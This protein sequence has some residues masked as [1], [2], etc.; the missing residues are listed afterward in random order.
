MRHL[1]ILLLTIVISTPVWAGGKDE[2]DVFAR[3]ECQRD[4]VIAGDS[5]VI[6]IVLYSSHPFQK[7]ECTTK[8]IKIKGCTPRLVARRGNRQQQ[9]VRLSQGIYYAIVWDSYVVG[10]AQPTEIKFPE[11]QFDCQVE[12]VESEGYDPFDPFGFFGRPQRKSRE[13]Q[14]KCKAP[15]FV[16]PVIERPK[17]STQEAISSGSRIA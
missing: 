15:A 10:H 13:V 16:L 8:N 2:A 6:N 12:I 3:Y 14:Q 7:A 5:I 4:D 17:R 1:L 11:V 9:R